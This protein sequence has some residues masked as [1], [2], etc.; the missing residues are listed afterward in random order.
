[1]AQSF[2][3]F[4]KEKA[5]EE[6]LWKDRKRYFGLPISFTQYILT[7]TKLRVRRGFF[8]TETDDVL[9]YRVLDVEV[10]RRFSQK[11][12]GVGTINIYATDR[13]TPKIEL[14]NVKRPEMVGDYLSEVVERVR[15]EKRITG[16]E[17]FGAGVGFAPMPGDLDGDGIPDA[18]EEFQGS[19]T[20]EVDNL[21]PTPYDDYRN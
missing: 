9:L 14:K 10:N 13:T 3:D 1:M 19:T 18:A 7:G 8:N 12:F 11:I 20:V 5:N 4:R 15:D 6:I 16:R 2:R 21:D 17:M